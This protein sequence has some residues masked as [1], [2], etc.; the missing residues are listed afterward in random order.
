MSP[1]LNEDFYRLTD[2]FDFRRLQWAS[3]S[4]GGSKF[5]IKVG[6]RAFY[7]NEQLVNFINSRF[8]LNGDFQ[9]KEDGHPSAWVDLSGSSTTDMRT[10]EHC[11]SLGIIERHGVAKQHGNL[12]HSTKG[13]YIRRK[14]NLLPSALLNKILCFTS[15]L[16]SRNAALGVL[17]YITIICSYVIYAQPQMLFHPVDGISNGLLQ[18]DGPGF[19]EL[20]MIGLFA[21]ILHEIGHASA[22]ARFNLKV[23]EIGFGFYWVLPVF[24]TDVTEA[25]LLRPSERVIINLGGVYFECI[26]VAALGVLALISRSPVLLL[27]FYIILFNVISNLVP[28]FR[29]DGYWIYSDIFGL[30]N[31][32]L[33]VKLAYSNSFRRMFSRGHVKSFEDK[34]LNRP[35]FILYA[36]ILPFVL[37]V[38]IYIGSVFYIKLLRGSVQTFRIL[39]G[40]P[41]LSNFVHAMIALVY[42]YGLISV[43]VLFGKTALRKLSK[44]TARHQA[45]SH[46][47]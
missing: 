42:L 16:F 43:A 3:D 26:Y 30:N 7:C 15:I 2:R 22:A 6:R 44:L 9:L 19:I 4:N 18:I 31:L 8:N 17:L 27:A 38:F 45:K 20:F 21:S 23:P 33:D 14:F 24:F 32:S 29:T 10:I 1:V 11:M 34:R 13:E 35:A 41:S 39:Y 40:M 25:W 37:S 12:E 36:A 5:Y 28:F 46:A 47:S